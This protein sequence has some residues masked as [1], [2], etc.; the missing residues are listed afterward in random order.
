MMPGSSLYWH[1]GLCADFVLALIVATALGLRHGL[2]CMRC[3]PWAA[4]R[5]S[6]PSSPARRRTIA[7]DIERGVRVDARLLFA[8]FRLSGKVREIRAGNHEIPPGTTP[9]ALLDKLVRGEESL[10][11]LTLVEGWTFRQMRAPRWLREEL[12]PRHRSCRR[13]D[14]D[15]A[16]GPGVPPRAASSGYL[17]LKGSSDS[18]PR[19]ARH[20]SPHSS[21]LA[22]RG[23]DTPPRAPMRHWSWPAL[24][25][26]ETA[27]RPTGRRSP[28]CLPTACAP[29]CCCRPTRP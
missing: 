9:I 16:I 12:A 5:W 4:S 1:Q 3:C 18:P 27:R 26:K 6:R 19:T 2:G 10:R 20:G 28:G 23:A 14:H 11:S 17:R 22:Q 21:R 8:W 24:S 29:A 25:K 13:R 15:A 7:R